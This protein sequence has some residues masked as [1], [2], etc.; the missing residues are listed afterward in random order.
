MGGVLKLEYDFGAATLTSVT[1]YETL[2][3]YS[4]GDIDGGYGAVFLPSGGG[5]GFIPFPSESADG[6]PE[7]RPVHPGAAPGEQHRRR[8]RLAGRRLLLQR[9][10]P[11]RHLQLRLAG[12]GQPAGRATPS[13][14]RTPRPG[15]S[16]ARSTGGRPSLDAQG[17]PALHRRREGL[18]GRA[19]GPD[20][21]DA[22]RRPDP[23]SRPTPT[24]SPGTSRRP[25]RSARR[26]PLR[27][28]RHRLPRAVDP[29]PHPVLRRLRGRHRTRPPTASR[30]PTRRRSCRSRSASRPILPT[31]SCA[32]TSTSTSTRSTASRSPRSAA[33][34]TPRPCSTPTRPT[35]TASRPTSTGCRRATG[36]S[37]SACSY[38]K[39]E[40]DD[41]NLT[42][43]HVRRRLHDHRSDRRRP[44][45]RRRQHAAARAGVD[46]QRHRQL[47]APGRRRA[48]HPPASTGP[49]TARRASSSTSRRSSVADWLR[50]RRC[51][52][53]T[54][55][56]RQVRGGAV[57][58]QPHR[59][60]DRPERH[61]L[62]QPHRHDQR[63]A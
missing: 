38:N 26:Q 1:G 35:A 13:R 57:R 5:P 9:E 30:W 4:R 20:L 36:C 21:P 41:P 16:S 39:T 11:G 54:A 49:T 52:S 62:Q 8:L 42:V 40:I 56:R 61:R 48:V 50:A 33:S 58:A 34:T 32:S 15:R 53:A 31:A 2:D 3:M 63:A 27:P 10:P 59:R 45:L 28:R 51:A 18:R 23:G 55:S 25:T 29:G 22:D 60:G 47:P 12:A 19:A 7:P 14:P 6:I 17:R 46:L 37:P 43:A 44:R 24:S